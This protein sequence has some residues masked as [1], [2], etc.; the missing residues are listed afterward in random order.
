MAWTRHHEIVIMMSQRVD[1]RRRVRG[2]LC[3][4]AT[5]GAAPRI[6]C[7]TVLVLLLCAAS[8]A[9]TVQAG[10]LQEGLLDFQQGRFSEALQAWWRADGAGDPRG[11]LY[12]G[13]LYDSG[14]GVRQDYAKAMAWY[15]RAA[16]LGSGAG[17]F[18]VGVMYD[19]GL[20][21]GKSARQAAVWYER[22]G[23]QGF[24]RADYN[25]ALLYEAG[26]GVPRNRARAV[27]LY[28]LAA[29]S[30]ISA[31]RE[32]L[33]ALHE[34]APE[35]ARQAP[36]DAMQGFR[37]AQQLLLSRGAAESAHMVELFRQ[38]AGQH[39]ALAEYDLGYCYDAG[40][41]VHRDPAQAYA[42]YRRAADDAHDNSL[43][44]LAQ[45]GADSARSV[46]R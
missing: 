31:A 1:L 10:L 21:V 6:M 39:N 30:G 24:G 19:S 34:T 44:A 33:A 15:R 14:L 5:G 42:W 13:V 37:Q 29:R 25:L 46:T 45:E 27:I 35:T 11:A 41:G 28:K 16:E 40:I 17:S 3:R 32:H 23:R 20:G 38:A 2:R 8:A 26:S 7:G 43:K 9:K 12:I 22:A 36:E 18:N 4:M